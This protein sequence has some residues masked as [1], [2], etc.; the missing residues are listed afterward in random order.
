MEKKKKPTWTY[1]HLHMVVRAC[2]VPSFKRTRTL[3]ACQWR[4]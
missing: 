3:K 4:N 1:N 2:S